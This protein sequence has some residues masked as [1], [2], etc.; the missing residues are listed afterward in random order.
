[1]TG[2]ACS[3]PVQNVVLIT[4]D[5]LRADH[6]GVY[7]GPVPTPAM[8][9]LAAEGV[10]VDGA[11]TPTPSTGPAHVSLLTG[12]HPWN[13]GVLLNAVLFDDPALSNLTET[14]QVAGFETAAFVSS[15]NVDKRWGFGRGFKSFHFEPTQDM[16]EKKFWSRGE[17]TTTAALDWLEEH[18]QERF[19]VW[20]HYF[21]PHLPYKPPE[22]YERPESEEIDLAGKGVPSPLRNFPQLKKFIR[23]YRGEVTYTDAQVGRLVD[24]LRRLGV[25]DKTAIVLTADHGEGLGDHDH[26]GHG[27]NLHD[28]LVTVPLIL[29]A[30]GLPAGSRL[31]GGAQLEDLMPTILSLVDVAVPDGLDGIDLSG[32][33]EGTDAVSPRAAV[34]GRRAAFPNEPALFFERRWPRKWIGETIGNGQAYR[35][36]QDAGEHAAVE[37][38]AA[39]DELLS[40]LADAVSA[41][42]RVLDDETRKALEALGYL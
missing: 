18:S 24:G 25:V 13:H 12:L 22:G 29:R 26:L 20:L 28:E 32:W 36:D 1:M 30:P 5:T 17:A 8:D 34:Y 19:F 38:P 37:V 31:R 10:T 14:L 21:D 39:P 9:R 7:G 27:W 41:R 16:K 33:L 35:L 6:V 40:R 23:G 4:V 15:F 11:C 2:Q 3:K 42:E